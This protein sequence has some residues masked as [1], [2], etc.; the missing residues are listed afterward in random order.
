MKQRILRKND[1]NRNT[2]NWMHHNRH[3]P[4]TIFPM[5]RMTNRKTMQNDIRWIR[6]RTQSRLDGMDISCRLPQSKFYWYPQKLN[7]YESEKRILWRIEMMTSTAFFVNTELNWAY[8]R[9][10]CCLRK[11][12]RKRG[13]NNNILTS[14]LQTS[15]RKINRDRAV[16]K[17]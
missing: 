11:N 15:E 4:F 16:H 2:C 3:S 8:L 13:K 12:V 14:P 17:L 9:R 5:D 7:V 6:N 10:Y 1:Y